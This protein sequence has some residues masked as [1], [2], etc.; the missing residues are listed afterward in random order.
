MIKITQVFLL[1]ILPASLAPAAVVVTD[2]GQTAPIIGGTDTGYTG[3]TNSRWGWDAGEGFSQSFTISGDGVVQSIFLGYNG[4]D[5]GETITLDLL[6]NGSVVENGIVLSGDNFS[7]SSATDN[8]DGVFYWMEFDLS[9]ENVPV[10]AG[11]NTFTMNATANTGTN[12][13]LA[14]RYANDTDAYPEGA[15][16]LDFAGTGGDVA[17]AVTVIPEPSSLALMG[18]A[19]L[20]LLARRHR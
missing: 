10:S 12:W 20:G 9:S 13:A 6:V 1:I 14:P 5:D 11:L 7:G 15:M 4:F 17:F 19:A 18:M 16:S 2:N 3:S 8:N